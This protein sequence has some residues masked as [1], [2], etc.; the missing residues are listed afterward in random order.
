[1]RDPPLSSARAARRRAIL[2]A[3]IETFAEHGF[4]ASR[5]REIA[6]RAGVAEGTIYLYFESKDDLLLTAF[7]ERVREFSESARSLLAEPLTFGE[8]LTRF[9]E[10]QLRSI[11]E[12]PA[13]AT[14]LLLETRHSSKFYGEPVREV[15]RGYAGAIDALIERGLETGELRPGLD[16]PLVRR[17]L[18]GTL[19]E[20]E[21]DWLLGERTRPLAG[22][23]RD[24]AA[25]LCHGILADGRDA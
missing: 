15:L 14:V 4:H 7:R 5:T 24:V 10:L 20:V 2:D 8:R 13:L 23:G 3:A 11:E 6:A 22:R 17:I 1:M 25:V 16:V 21:L 19:E 18:V 12:N 9:V